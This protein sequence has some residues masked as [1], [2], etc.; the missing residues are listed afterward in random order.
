MTKTETVHTRV[1]PDIKRK[2]DSIFESIGLT[3]SQSIMEWKDDFL[4]H[5]KH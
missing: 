5:F 1:T 4:H 2:A 3:I